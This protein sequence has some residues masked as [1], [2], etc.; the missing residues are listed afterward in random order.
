MRRQE[1]QDEKQRYLLAFAAVFAGML[2]LYSYMQQGQQ[3]SAEKN[4]RNAPATDAVT[5]QL[6]SVIWC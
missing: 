1:V 4:P 2:R 5:L 6:C 3:A